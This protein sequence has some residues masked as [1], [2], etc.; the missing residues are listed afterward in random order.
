MNTVESRE[1]VDADFA[2]ESA[3]LTRAQSNNPQQQLA[4]ASKLCKLY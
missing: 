1:I 2:K 3:N 4:Q